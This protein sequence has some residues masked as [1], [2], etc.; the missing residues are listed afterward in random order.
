MDPLVFSIMTSESESASGSAMKVHPGDCAAPLDILEWLDKFDEKIESTSYGQVRRG[1]IPAAL[2]RSTEPKDLSAMP[3]LTVGTGITQADVEKRA[4]YIALT[5]AENA[6]MTAE[7]ES[8]MRD[9][10]NR[11]AALVVSAMRETALNT[12]TELKAKFEDSTVSGMY[13]GPAMLDEMRTKAKAELA[14]G[15]D[16]TEKRAVA[17]LDA[18]KARVPPGGCASKDMA[19][20][21]GPYESF[22]GSPA[23]KGQLQFD[24][25]GV[26]PSDRWEWDVL[27]EEIMDKGMRNSLLV[28]PMPTAST[29][30]ILGNNECFEPYTS[31]IYTRRTLSGEFIVVN[32]H[33]LRD[34]TKL[35]LWDADMKN[36]LIAAN[37]SVQNIPNIPENLKQL[38]RTA[39]EISQRAI[40]DMAADR[41]AYI[42]QSQSLNVFMENANAPKLTSMHFHAW[43]SGLKTGMYY[44]R[45]KAATDAIKFTVDKKYKEQPTEAIKEVTEMTHEEQVAACSIENGPDCEMCSG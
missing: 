1:Q 43:R 15:D 24:M 25:W 36:Q 39:W 28:A 13:D 34:L 10:K 19:I 31:N 9:Y 42:C 41:G 2:L 21:E 37:G 20:E 11:L 23:S 5:T 18:W 7:R 45:T 30:Q 12:L 27:K 16:E 35:G 17:E 33:L 44:L 38:Y 29:A 32:N 40:L 14:A 6:R 22:K 3:P 8:T 26:T 4:T